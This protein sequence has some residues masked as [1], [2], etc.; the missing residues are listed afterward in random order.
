MAVRTMKVKGQEKQVKGNVKEAVG[1]VTGNDRMKASGRTDV[2][3]G[4]AQ[5]AV[6]DASQK[7]KK[8]AKRIVGN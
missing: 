3:E 7:V 2:S 5:A 1:K 4:K 6:G 8:F